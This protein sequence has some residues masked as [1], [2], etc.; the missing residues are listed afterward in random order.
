MTIY[1]DCALLR[2]LLEEVQ[3]VCDWEGAVSRK[4]SLIRSERSLTTH[5]LRRP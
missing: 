3:K 4:V 2:T 1:K 5:P